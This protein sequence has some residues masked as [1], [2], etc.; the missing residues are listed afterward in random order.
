MMMNPQDLT[1]GSSI[2]DGVDKEACKLTVP[3]G[4]LAKYKN[5]MPW[6]LFFN[7]V[8]VD[9]TIPGDVNADGH[10][11]S[12]DV[13]ALYSYLLN[14]DDSDIVNGDQDGDGYITSGDVTTVY[15][16]LLGQ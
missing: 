3:I 14:N 4:T 10:V 7:I 1:Y 11:T 6:K 5:T 15:S 2:F 8:Q 13:T 9:G 16:N 12:A